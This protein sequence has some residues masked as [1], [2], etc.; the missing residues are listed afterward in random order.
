MVPLIV[1]VLGAIGLAWWL[2]SPL[3]FDET[4]DEQF[5][6]TANA[7][8]PAGMTRAVA[9]QTMEEAATRTTLFPTMWT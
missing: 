8:L 5:P 4:V 1:G 6:L 7:S 3:L 9:E 2:L